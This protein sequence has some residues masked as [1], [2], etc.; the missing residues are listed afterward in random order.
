MNHIQKIRLPYTY[1]DVGW[2]YQI[3]VPQIP[4]G[5]LDYAVLPTVL[6]QKIGLDG[7]VPSALT[8]LRDIG[9][10]VARIVTD[11]RTLN[12]K[13]FAYNEVFTQNQV[14]NLVEELSGESL[15]R[16]YVCY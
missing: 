7:N 14:Y 11:V 9:R 13:V 6:N 1:I 15:E 4:S 10:Y 3:T 8:D 16:K 2:W 12:K 5:R